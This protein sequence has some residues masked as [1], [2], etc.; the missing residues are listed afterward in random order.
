MVVDAQSV[1]RD[2][3][4][5][6][7]RTASATTQQNRL[8][9]LAG[10]PRSG[11]T[12]VQNMMDSHPDVVGGPEF[13]HLPDVVLL[14]SKLLDSVGRGWIDLF[15]SAEDV[16]QHI[17][18]LVEKLLL[19]FADRHGGRFLSE[20]SPQNTLVLP[21]LIE[22]FPDA[23]FVWIVRDPRAVIA[24]LL[25]TGDRA[26]RKGERPPTMAADLESAIRYTG[27]CMQAA[28]KAVTEAPEKVHT[29]VYER[30]VQE[31]E[32]ESRRLCQF[33]GLTWSDEMLKPAD[34]KHLGET[35]ITVNSKEIWYDSDMYYSNPSADRL[36]K[37]RQELAPYQQI[38]VNRAFR[39][40]DGLRRFGYDF[41]NRHT[42]RIGLSS[43]RALLTRTRWAIVRRLRAALAE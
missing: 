27:R 3:P 34:K 29:L 40:F 16:D 38:L 32:Q 12:L 25:A 24:S 17:R 15:C 23:K 11:T 21:E 7:N 26:R 42:G 19:P 20:K 31:P 35:A 13:L 28:F 8:I 4:M 2:H 43:I 14:R 39:R 6:R 41:S 37:W 10:C 9:F 5:G 18:T 36:D 22:L 33:L 1:D 30:L